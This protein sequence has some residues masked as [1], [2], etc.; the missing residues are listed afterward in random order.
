MLLATLLIINLTNESLTDDSLIP[1]LQKLL[2]ASKLPSHAM[3]FQFTEADAINHLKQ[4]QTMT[5]ALNKLGCKVAI[6]RFGSAID[7]YK[8][9]EHI[10]SDFVK[11]DG[12]FT[13]ELNTEQGMESLKTLLAGISEHEKASIVPFVENANIVAQLWTSG[14]NFIQGFYLSGPT[15]QMNYEFNDD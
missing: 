11:V 4:A 1:W 2:Q 8:L 9:F 5:Q 15:T 10:H 12:S 7:P 14:V 3:I 13:K 6:S